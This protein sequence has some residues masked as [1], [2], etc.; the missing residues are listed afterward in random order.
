MYSD[1][2]RFHTYWFTFSRVIA[3]RVNIARKVN[4]IFGQSQASSRITRTVSTLDI[5]LMLCLWLMYDYQHGVYCLVVYSFLC[6]I[7]CYWHCVIHRSTISGPSRICNSKSGPGRIWKKNQ[8]QCNPTSNRTTVTVFITVWP[9]PFDLW[10]NAYRATAIEYMYTKFGV[11]SV[12]LLE[13]RQTDRQ[14]DVTE[15]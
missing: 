7:A 15:H 3:E 4:P 11:D 5:D 9:W 2:S 14:T 13:C 10:V 1:G 6:L 8:I 12:F